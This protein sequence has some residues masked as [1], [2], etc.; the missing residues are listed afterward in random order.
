M[1]TEAFRGDEKAGQ[2]HRGKAM[3]QMMVAL[4][5]WLSDA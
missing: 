2:S 4:E 5:R 1:P 3:A